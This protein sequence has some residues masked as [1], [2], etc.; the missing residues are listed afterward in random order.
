MEKK[1][2]WLK[3]E[4]LHIFAFAA[5]ADPLGYR[6]EWLMGV[7]RK[8]RYILWVNEAPYHSA[9]SAMISFQRAIFEEATGKPLD[10]EVISHPRDGS[11]FRMDTILKL[12]WGKSSYSTFAQCLDSN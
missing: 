6:I 2:Q 8:D 4:I 1:T 9:L 12:F 3:M 5:N 11:R 7:D 10:L